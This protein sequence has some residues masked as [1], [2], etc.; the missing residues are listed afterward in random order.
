MSAIFGG[1]PKVQLSLDLQTLDVAL[2]TADIAV[3]AGVDWLEVGTPL[4]LG[5][6]LHAVRALHERYPTHPVVADLKTMDAGFLE[7]EM[8][9]KAGASFV[10][11]MGQAHEH[12]I[13]EA[14]RAA[15]QYGRYVMGDVML[16]PDKVAMAQMMEAMGVDVVIVHTGLD[17]RH[18]ETGKSPLD[19][20]RRIRPAVKC[21][22][23]AVGG[24]SID[25]AAECP[26]LGADLVVI[27][28]PLAVADHEL[29]PG[30]D[31]ETLFGII[32]S[33]VERVKGGRGG[34]ADLQVGPP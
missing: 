1:G 8:M 20:L 14:V 23:Q 17:E 2:A 6:G 12:T 3:R 11:V 13:R 30:A 16:C 7:A 9:F 5:E 31:A 33:F 24:L 22:L 10:V 27:G 29:K 34:G 28:A 18:W 25:Q 32:Q 4:I 19:D 21:P 15:R 26:S